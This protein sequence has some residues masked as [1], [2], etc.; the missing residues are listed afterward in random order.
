MRTNRGIS[1]TGFQE[2]TLKSWPDSAVIHP[3]RYT[4]YFV[5]NDSTGGQQSKKAIVIFTPEGNEVLSSEIV[6]E[7]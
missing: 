7:K 4:M 2:D 1:I 3:I 6:V 5:Y